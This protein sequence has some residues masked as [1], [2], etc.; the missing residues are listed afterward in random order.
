MLLLL[1]ADAVDVVVVAVGNV[2]AA[3]AVV[4]LGV[5]VVAA[6]DVD[7][8]I[9]IGSTLI[10]TRQ[11]RYAVCIIHPAPEVPKMS[12]QPM[13]SCDMPFVLVFATHPGYLPCTREDR[14]T[15]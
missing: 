12:V 7:S 1:V 11:V 3:V 14:Y 13:F 4:V 8:V 15:V 6:I 10:L 5:V 9:I 2:V